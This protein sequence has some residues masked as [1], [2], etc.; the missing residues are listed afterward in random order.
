MGIEIYSWT[1][2]RFVSSMKSRIVSIKASG[3]GNL[4][5]RHLRPKQTR[6]TN[7]LMSSDL[8]QHLHCGYDD[9]TLIVQLFHEARLGQDDEMLKDLCE[10]EYEIDFLHVIKDV[11]NKLQETLEISVFAFYNCLPMNKGGV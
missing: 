5:P 7:L 3:S 6:G 4:S 1:I 8:S 2:S 10:L 9:L 11:W